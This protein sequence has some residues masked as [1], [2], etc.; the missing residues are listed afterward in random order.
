MDGLKGRRKGGKEE[1]GDDGRW[2]FRTNR[3]SPSGEG[4][5]LPAEKAVIVGDFRRE[6]SQLRYEAAVSTE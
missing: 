2:W 1:G 6:N 5:R 3:K 4:E